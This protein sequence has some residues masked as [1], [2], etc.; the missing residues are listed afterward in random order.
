MT[1]DFFSAIDS[2]AIL[3]SSSRLL[4]PPPSALFSCLPLP[5]SLPTYHH[6][7]ICPFCLFLVLPSLFLLFFPPSLVV[8]IETRC[9]KKWLVSQKKFLPKTKNRFR[10]FTFQP[11]NKRG[12]KSNN[13]VGGVWIFSGTACLRQNVLLIKGL[14]NIF[15]NI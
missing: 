1:P 8:K 14:S 10:T 13:F 15:S 3:D 12:F 4:Y 9:A 2:W 7:S 11:R 6:S 5:S